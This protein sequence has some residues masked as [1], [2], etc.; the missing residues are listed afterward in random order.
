M[1]VKIKRFDKNL[2]VPKYQTAGAVGFDIYNRHE[3]TFK[4][5]E[6][7]IFST[8]LAVEVPRGH[9][10]LINS[11]SS[12]AIKVGLLIIP[13]VVDQDFCGD[14]DELHIQGMNLTKKRLKIKRGIRVAQGIFVKIFKP[15]LMEVKK[16][17]SKSRG[18]F[19]T[20]G[21]N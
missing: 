3:E 8:N 10:L 4:P 6:I 2:P 13:G 15:E 18:G 14:A 1:K 9:F 20:T 12:T 16:L 19:G 7:K 17:D 5:G 21:H 11:R